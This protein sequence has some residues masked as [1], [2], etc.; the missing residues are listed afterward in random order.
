MKIA[1][2]TATFPPYWAG[3]GN[4]AYH[5][6]RLLHERGH[7]V[8]VF[9]A[10]TKRDHELSFPFDV[11]RLPV[12]FRV[13]NAPLTPRLITELQGFD[14][15][16]LHYPFIFGAELTV[17]AARQHRIPL[18]VTYH[19]DLI[20]RGLRGRLFDVYNNT[21]Q[22]TVL[23]QASLLVGTS[24][25]YAQHSLFWRTKSRAAAVRVLPN[26]VDT[27][28]FRP[29]EKSAESFALFVGGLDR[30]HHFKGVA[31]LIE[32]MRSLPRRAVIVGDGDMRAEY[33]RLAE[34]VAPGRVEFAGR[35]PLDE[36]ARL[37]AQATVTVLPSTTQGEAFGMV[38]IE[39]MASGTAVIATDLP[40]VRTVVQ[41]GHDGL[42]VPPG[43]SGAL[44]SALETLL[45]QPTLAHAMG[46]RG[47]V[48]VHSKY[49]WNVIGDELEQLYEQVVPSTGVGREW[50]DTKA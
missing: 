21:A 7:D 48:K 1:H 42:L 44:A 17:L 40:G 22:P 35:V 32:A 25:D 36:L 20:A 4:V 27:R 39:A 15:I 6:A 31:V 23:S 43:D 29:A 13:G 14:V 30:A 26:G 41:H 45:S 12:T 33:E 34:E 46:E 3:T 11:R 37:Y 10:S 9:T 8:V 18:V 47:R 49:D 24:L 2:V 50:Q 38:L 16:H 5:N 19:N 28:A